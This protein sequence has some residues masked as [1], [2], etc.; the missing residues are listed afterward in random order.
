MKMSKI[1]KTRS[2]KVQGDRTRRAKTCRK[3]N[4]CLKKTNIDAGNIDQI[5]TP[6]K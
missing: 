2:E 4:H 3:H 1:V 5:Y 6:G